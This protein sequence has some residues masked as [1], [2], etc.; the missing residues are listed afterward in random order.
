VTAHAIRVT[1]RLAAAS[2]LSALSRVAPGG[3]FG[4]SASELAT[5]DAY[6]A[7]FNRQF[8]LYGRR[9]VLVPYQGRND[10][11]AED[12]GAG[13]VLTEED[14]ATAARTLHAFADVSLVDSSLPYDAALAD[15]GVVSLGLPA[16]PATDYA[17]AAPWEYTAGPD[18][19]K[20]AEATG[21]VLG[22]Q[23]AGG[24]AALAG[25]PGLRRTVRRFGIVSVALPA[26]AA[27]ARQTLAQLARHHVG[28][29]E[30]ATLPFALSASDSGQSAAEA[31]AAVA[32]MKAGGVTSV[33]CSP[34]DPLA[35]LVLMAA[36]DRLDYHPEWWVEPALAGAQTDTDA[37]TRILPP[38]QADHL[39][40]F[41]TA[42]LPYASQEAV[43]AFRAGEPD[44]GARPAASFAATYMTLLE[45]FD[46]LQLAG[47]DLTP[48]NL[49]VAMGRLP[50]S[51]PGG[52][53][54]GWDGAAGPADPAATYSV[55]KWFA[56]RPSPV[57]GRP[58][59]WV[60]CDAGRL[61]PY[62][63]PG[64]RV[65][66]HATL[67]CTPADAAGS[68]GHGGPATGGPR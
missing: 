63:G 5:L 29:A 45:L 51:L 7:A 53:L 33:I 22:R 57:D 60:A 9:V 61:F 46:A 62:A 40:S 41:G 49:A 25:D 56:A 14:A 4:P 35:P 32:Q 21:A 48:R 18:C 47:P 38:D 3:P 8:E 2:N 66:A 50:R 17:A 54:G 1:V 28:V 43:R 44:P 36:A 68:S 58:G 65:P 39:I 24:P 23:L 34:C 15:D 59:T 10:F 6:V 13:A 19:T 30:S 26:G 12:L 27:C 11:V 37:L 67:V 31:Q 20:A 42:P 64:P 55:L 52:M 16:L